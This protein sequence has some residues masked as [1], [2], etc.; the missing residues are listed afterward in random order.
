MRKV[1]SNVAALLLAVSGVALTARAQSVPPTGFFDYG[2]STATPANANFTGAPF[3]DNSTASAN[4]AISVLQANQDAKKALAVK[5]RE[6]LTNADALAVFNRFKVEYVFADFEDSARVGRTRAIADQVLASTQSKAAYVGNFNFYPNAGADTT[7]PADLSKSGAR[8]FQF[9]P[10]SADYFDSRGRPAGS[11][12]ATGNQSANASLYPGAP[13]FRNPANGNSNAPN[14]RSALFILPIQ[15]ETFATNGLLN[16]SVPGAKATTAYNTPF[17]SYT[18]GAKNIPYVSRFN[19]WGNAALDSDGNVANGYQFVQNAATPSNGQLLSRGD[20]QAQVLHYRLRGADTV[21]L[22]N[23]SN[24]SVVGYSDA[25]EQSDVQTGWGATSATNGNV[26]NGIFSR[27]NYAF[28]NLTN[29]IG[30]GGQQTGDTNPR[31]TEIAGAVWSGVFDRSGNGRRLA[32]LISNLSNVQKT[33]DLPNKIG[34]FMTARNDGVA[35]DDFFL[36]PGQ[37]K[38]LTF[39]L[40]GNRWRLDTNGIQIVFQ[41]NNRNGVGIP[42]P[43][44]L[45]LLG[46]GALGL[47]ARRR[48]QD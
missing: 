34:G 44:S 40:N 41:D 29:V 38:L 7:F 28:A 11:N 15:R 48:R 16:R 19:N 4:N 5:I 20:F 6:P 37:H 24:G 27:K 36:D 12:K 2:E 42:E 43:T 32:V 23:E 13:D 21:H 3:L 30:D 33:I 14:I 1:Q 25:Q 18:N 9:R 10:T 8:S 26:V 47:L 22:F 35:I 31:S 46:V 45:S 17:T 39:A